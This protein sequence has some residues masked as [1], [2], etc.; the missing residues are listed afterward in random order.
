MK[1]Y[2]TFFIIIFTTSVE[3]YPKILTIKENSNY[4]LVNEK[5]LPIIDINILFNFGSKNDLSQ[6]G[7]TNFSVELLHQQKYKNKKFINTFEEI[8]AQFSSSVSR[9]S[10]SISIRFINTEKNLTKI[11]SML[12]KMLSNKDI[13]NETFELTKESILKNIKARELDP[14]SI[15]SYKSNEEYFSNTNLS[16]PIN[17]YEE[18]IIK[19]SIDDI[20]QHLIS[21]ITQNGIKVSFVGDIDNSQAANFISNLLVDIPNDHKKIVDTELNNL[22]VASKTINFKH[23]SEQ[24]H[25]SI[26]IP[27]V[28]REDD[29]FYNL[30]V[31]NYIFGGSGFGSML[32]TEIR[33]KNGL[34]YSVFSYLMPYKNVGVLKIGMQTATNNTNKAVSILNDQLSLFEQ[35]DLD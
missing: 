6:K 31:A 35:F 5:S 34:A 17:G 13:S 9:E 26:M 22:N 16:H 1:Y 8:G 19:I 29:D 27:A 18:N 28:T 23:D 4:L 11:S 10:T 32:M 12:G 25:I 24:T 15:L 3:S 30:L 2:I 21:L 14:S 7:I 20:K 33:E